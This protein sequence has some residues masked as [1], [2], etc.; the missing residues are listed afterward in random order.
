MGTVIRAIDAVDWS[1]G[2][3]NCDIRPRLIDKSTGISRLIDSGSQIS[4]TQ[5]LPGDSID[6]SLKL[7]AVNGSKIETYGVREVEFKIGRKAYKMPAVV[8]DVKQDIL[9]MDFITKFRLNFEWDEF[10]QT[11]LYLVDRKAQSKALLQVV[12]VPLDTPRVSSISRSDSPSTSPPF[13][14]LGSRRSAPQSSQPRCIPK[15]KNENVEFQVACMKLLDSKSKG[16]NDKS[17][18]SNKKSIE[19]Q[20]AMHGDEYVKMIKAHPQLLNPDFKKGEPTH[21][22]YHKIETSDNIPCKTKRRPI[23]LDSEKA[24]KGKEAW[25]KMIADGVVEEV[26]AGTNTDWSSA[27]HLAPKAGGGVRPCSDFRAQKLREAPLRKVNRYF[28]KQ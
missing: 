11:E 1:I 28:R 26:K 22:V 24:R 10:D 16:Q 14:S 25:D 7:V 8:C 5:K 9:G 18:Q 2:R 12:T 3:H 6:K 21:G 15:N 20:L 23:V 27:L 17:D 4:V 13:S 19:E